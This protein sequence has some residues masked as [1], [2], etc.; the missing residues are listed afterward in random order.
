MIKLFTLTKLWF[1]LVATLAGVLACGLGGSLAGW[2]PAR[3]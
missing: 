3:S 2:W 1:K